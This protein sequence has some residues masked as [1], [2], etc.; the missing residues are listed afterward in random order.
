MGQKST[1]K[2]QGCRCNPC[3]IPTCMCNTCF[4]C[5]LNVNKKRKHYAKQACVRNTNQEHSIRDCYQQ[6]C[7]DNHEEDILARRN[8]KHLA[9][10]NRQRKKL[11]R[12][13]VRQND[14]YKG[15]AHSRS[16]QFDRGLIVDMSPPVDRSEGSASIWQRMKVWRK[17]PRKS[18]AKQDGLEYVSADE[19][20]YRNHLYPRRHVNRGFVERKYPGLSPR[21][22]VK[23]S[24]DESSKYFATQ[25]KYNRVPNRRLVM[26]DIDYETANPENMMYI[27]DDNSRNNQTDESR[28]YYNEGI[29][30][31]RF[32]SGVKYNI[33]SLSQVNHVYPA[34]NDNH[35]PR[36]FHHQDK[37]HYQP[38]GYRGELE[39][40]NYQSSG[41][42]G[43]SE[44]QHYQPSG[45]RG[46][47]EKRITSQLPENIQRNFAH[48]PEE[49]YRQNNLVTR[50]KKGHDMR[51]YL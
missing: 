14:A 16:D 34:S 42:R 21:P 11:P 41:Y 50:D 31:R 7:K 6:K 24:E 36:Q 20:E 27:I 49:M 12:S 22:I 47:S 17:Q 48:Y 43:A 29:D 32:S 4:P 46:A 26:Q 5:D 8:L 19:L 51:K 18:H 9:K 25:K 2:C 15:L 45:Y 30:H 40:Q 37:R 1:K 39:K 35:L 23:Y 13:Y 44:K 38:S 10:S 3:R 33:N 28:Q